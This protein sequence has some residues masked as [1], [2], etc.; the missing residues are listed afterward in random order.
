MKQQRCIQPQMSTDSARRG[1]VEDIRDGLIHVRDA[2]D[3][4]LQYACLF[5]RNTSNPPPEFKPGDAVLFTFS[6]ISNEA[7]VLGLIEPYVS[8]SDRI[9]A[10]L[11]KTGRT[12]ST[13]TVE[14]E[15]VRIKAGK[16]LVIE[17]GKGTIIITEDGR[18]QIKGTDLLSRARG[19]NK[20]KGA[21][22]AL[23]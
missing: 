18:I 6:E 11:T 19:M 4:G 3:S 12:P 5:V 10:A 21:G 20:I 2:M 8:K 1:V 15:V 7:F 13:T 9:A 14:D 16:G 23:N 22:I 17:C